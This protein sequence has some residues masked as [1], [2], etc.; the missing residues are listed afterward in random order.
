M[1]DD[2]VFLIVVL[3]CVAAVH[4]LI[5]VYSILFDDVPTVREKRILKK[6]QRELIPY[7]RN[8]SV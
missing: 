8:V 4:Q 5:T 2:T 6:R 1:D 7:K 3:P